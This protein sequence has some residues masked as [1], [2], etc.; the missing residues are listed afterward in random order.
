MLPSGKVIFHILSFVLI[1]SLIKSKQWPE[2]Q[3]QT[4][5]FEIDFSPLKSDQTAEVAMVLCV[6]WL[7]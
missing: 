2:W 5:S 7:L 3:L 1:Q 4:C 6:I